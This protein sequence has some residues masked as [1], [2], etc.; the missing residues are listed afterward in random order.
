MYHILYVCTY[1]Y[2][3]IYT[4][5]CVCAF[6][7]DGYGARAATGASCVGAIGR[8]ARVAV[9]VSWTSRTTSAQWVARATHTTVIDA[10]GAI[11]VIGGGTWD[12][13]IDYRDVWA[14]TNGGA[15][16]TR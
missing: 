8:F 9:G 3:H 6:I 15:D 10:A 4:C 16:R 5:V 14:S 11:Y 13:S 2:I 1:V 7:A 12:G